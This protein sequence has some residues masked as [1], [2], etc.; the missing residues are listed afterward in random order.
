MNYKV[1]SDQIDESDEDKFLNHHQLLSNS[2]DFFSKAE[3]K[4][5][6]DLSQSR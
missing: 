2:S 5:T 6:K 1:F 3:G 4:C